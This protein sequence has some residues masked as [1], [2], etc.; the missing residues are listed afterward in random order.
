MDFDF[1][2]VR[3]E[4]IH[5]VVHHQHGT[6]GGVEYGEVQHSPEK[7]LMFAEF[8]RPCFKLLGPFILVLCKI[9]IAIEQEL[10]LVIRIPGVSENTHQVHVK[11]MQVAEIRIVV[12]LYLFTHLIFN[13]KRVDL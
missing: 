3:N 1:K 6:A 13:T 2:I 10:Q 8:L 5:S 9:I 12:T 11:F 7:I 4:R